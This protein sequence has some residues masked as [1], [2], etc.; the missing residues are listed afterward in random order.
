MFQSFQVGF[1]KAFIWCWWRWSRWEHM[2][3]IYIFRHSLQVLII[4]FTRK[5]I[6]QIYRKRDQKRFQKSLKWN[7][8]SICLSTATIAVWCFQFPKVYERKNEPYEMKYCRGIM[9][10]YNLNSPLPSLC[11]LGLTLSWKNG[12]SEET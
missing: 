4:V 10:Y 12:R 6:Y 1:C 5:A 7:L 11:T 8:Y 9:S 3:F 2:V